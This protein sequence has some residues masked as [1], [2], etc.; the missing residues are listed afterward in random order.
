[1]KPK[2][3]AWITVAVL[4][5][6][7]AAMAALAQGDAR[8]G[9]NAGSAPAACAKAR[10]YMLTRMSGDAYRN[11]VVAACP[12]PTTRQADG[13]WLTAG[14]ARATQYGTPV[15]VRWTAR[16]AGLDGALRVCGFGLAQ[17]PHAAPTLLDVAGCP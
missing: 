16:V 11:I 14:A 12:I 13:S 7:C 9:L 3:K 8:P 1:M 15:A 6:S 4:T 5:A 17:E 10:A 2:I